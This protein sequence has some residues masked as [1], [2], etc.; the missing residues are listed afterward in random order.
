MWFER[1]Y[2]DRPTESTMSGDPPYAQ[3]QAEGLEGYFRATAWVALIG[4]GSSTKS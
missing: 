4:I 2:F 1:V 3:S